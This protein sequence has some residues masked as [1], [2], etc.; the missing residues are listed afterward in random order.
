MLSADT[1]LHDFPLH[2]RCWSLDVISWES[3]TP[4]GGFI[5]INVHLRNPSK[6]AQC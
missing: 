6:M 1:K 4:Y 3:R 5:Y 2:A